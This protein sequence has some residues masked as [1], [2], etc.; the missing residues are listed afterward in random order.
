MMCKMYLMI[1]VLFSFISLEANAA[2]FPTAIFNAQ[3]YD[4][5][6]CVAEYKNIC[7]NNICL[8]SEQRDCIETCKQMAIGK[9]Q[10]QPMRQDGLSIR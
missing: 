8:T 6:N 2:I 10:V 1:F 4:A 3:K 9:C 5:F 7:V